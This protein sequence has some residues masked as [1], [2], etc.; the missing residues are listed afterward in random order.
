MLQGEGVSRCTKHRCAIRLKVSLLLPSFAPEEFIFF[1][2]RALERGDPH[3]P[4]RGKSE[5][6][7][8]VS[9]GATTLLINCFNYA[10]SA[11]SERQSERDRERSGGQNI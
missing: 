3:S 6:R 9:R 8:R 2:K 10:H 5:H 1:S 11:I 4:R 7:P